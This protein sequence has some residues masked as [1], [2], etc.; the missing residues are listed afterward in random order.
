MRMLFWPNRIGVWPTNNAAPGRTGVPVGAT[1]TLKSVLDEATSFSRNV[2]NLVHVEAPAKTFAI[3][4]A[5]SAVGA[6]GTGDT[7]H[8]AESDAANINRSFDG[9]CL[10]FANILQNYE[11]PMGERSD[12]L[13]RTWSKL[14]DRLIHLDI[15]VYVFGVGL[16]QDMPAE[17][18]AIQPE[19]LRLL[20]TLNDRAA[21]FGVRGEATMQWLHRLGLRKAR[22]LGCPSMFVYPANVLSVTPPALRPDSM[23]GTAGRLVGGRHLDRVRPLKLIGQT[24]RTDYAFQNDIWSLT[25]GHLDKAVFDDATGLLDRDF[26][27]AM[28]RARLG[29][30][31]PFG[32]YY[33]F[34][35]T[36]RWRMYA[37]MREAFVGDRFHGGVAF[38]QAARPALILQADARVREL[39]GYLGIP[40]LPVGDLAA[41]DVAAAVKDAL[42]DD[43]IGK[44][45]ATFRKRLREY[46]QAC[47]GAGLRFAD[48]AQISKVLGDEPA[49]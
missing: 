22:A 18:S 27:R 47:E 3:N 4:R 7:R 36:A 44:F 9:V 29:F 39:T 42:S 28:C 49:G 19:L 2:G 32:A 14:S 10:S 8:E 45:H 13:T 46:V 11:D 31:L 37:H 24:F 48:R 5:L 17:A 21:L 23:I 33:L 26:I 43:A 16:Q 30:E 6:L 20:T 35:D 15:P 12:Q 40:T 38:L 34:R 25:R 1:S 41:G